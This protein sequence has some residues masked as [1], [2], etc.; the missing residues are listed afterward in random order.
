MTDY[1]GK[2]KVFNEVKEHVD[3]SDMPKC[4]DCSYS[5][6]KG[7]EKLTFCV[8]GDDDSILLVECIRASY[9]LRIEVKDFDSGKYLSSDFYK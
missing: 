5:K 8:S 6:F 3:Y 7:L 9:G 2:T 4:K 1:V